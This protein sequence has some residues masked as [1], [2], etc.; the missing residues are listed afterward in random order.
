MYLM[1]VQAASWCFE[2]VGMAS[3]IDPLTPGLSPLWPFGGAETPICPTTLEMDASFWSR[4]VD[5]QLSSIAVLPAAI[6]L[7]VSSSRKVRDAGSVRPSVIVWRI[8]VSAATP[9]ALL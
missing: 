6:D 7:S 9:A 3:A 8:Q 4:R 5:S 1:N 2:P